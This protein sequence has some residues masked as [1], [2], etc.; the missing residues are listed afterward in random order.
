MSE[1]IEWDKV[2]EFMWTY[3]PHLMANH[4]L[5]GPM[6]EPIDNDEFQ[7]MCISWARKLQM[8]ARMEA[9]NRDCSEGD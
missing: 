8:Y 9:G 4:T 2:R 5:R 1:Q 3:A 7:R 6:R